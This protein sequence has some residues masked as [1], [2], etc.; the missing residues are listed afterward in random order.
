MSDL[1]GISADDFKKPDFIFRD[2]S[3]M[4]LQERI[5]YNI[6]YIETKIKRVMEF[7][8]I[9]KIKQVVKKEYEQDN[10]I[11]IDCDKCD[12]LGWIKA[13]RP[14]PNIRFIKCEC[15]RDD[16]NN[17][18]KKYMAFTGTTVFTEKFSN[19]VHNHPEE[20]KNLKTVKK[21][22]ENIGRPDKP[23]HLFLFGNV[24]TGKS[25]L[26]KA[27]IDFFVNDNRTG[28]YILYPEFNQLIKNFDE[29]VSNHIQT[30]M[31]LP[32]LIFDEMYMGYDR[33]GYASGTFNDIL[34]TRW[35][36]KMPTLVTGIIQPTQ[37]SNP[38]RS[39]FYDDQISIRINSWGLK[40]KRL[41]KKA[42]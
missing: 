11:I 33:S 30:L 29:N 39:R 14:D 7:D 15:S 31:K 37:L 13:A 16:L 36:R 38:I 6:R 24:G 28:R 40:D 25:H 20:Q 27:C 32:I 41:Q 3:K 42:F 18:Q 22:C 26:A 19:Y 4:N 2:Q 10:G 23:T 34:H 5:D 17:Y 12:N 35:A 1:I 8:E 9:E 21:W